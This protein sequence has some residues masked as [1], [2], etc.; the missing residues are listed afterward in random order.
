M[1]QEPR[2][3]C[4]LVTFVLSARDFLQVGPLASPRVPEEF[5]NLVCRSQTSVCR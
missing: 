2:Q 1:G 5:I 4:T 3:L